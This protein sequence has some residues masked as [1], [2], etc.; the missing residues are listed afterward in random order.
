MATTATSKR[1]QQA[2]GKQAGQWVACHALKCTLTSQH[3]TEGQFQATKLWL[4]DQGI[5][6]TLPKITQADVDSFLK[7][8]DPISWVDAYKAKDAENQARFSTPEHKAKIAHA[9]KLADLRN[10]ETAAAGRSISEML[11]DARKNL[12]AYKAER[13]ANLPLATGG[14]TDANPQSAV[15]P[16]TRMVS[17][18]EKFDVDSR[19]LSEL[20]TACQANNVSLVHDGGR[21][22]TYNSGITRHKLNNLRM[23]G[24]NADLDKVKDWMEDNKASRGLSAS[25]S[26]SAKTKNIE[27]IFARAQNLGIDIIDYKGEQSQGIFGGGWTRLDKVEFYGPAGKVRNFMQWLEIAVRS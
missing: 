11:K 6:K 26:I 13:E 4:A 16:N 3:I 12:D 25:A 20:T 5:K 10:A 21:K 23:T 9:K 17:T 18:Y 2:T 7:S 24:R 8:P 22:I 1:H 14:N 19:Y 15:G 27:Q